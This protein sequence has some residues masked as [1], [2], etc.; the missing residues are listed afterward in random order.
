MS[1]IIPPTNTVTDVNGDPFVGA[2]MNIFE[3]GTTT[4]KDI[5]LNSDF[6]GAA[7]N[8][9]I[10]D[11]N[12]RFA[13]AYVNGTHKVFVTDSLGAEIP[14]TGADNVEAVTVAAATTTVGGTVV[15]ATTAQIAA[16][17]TG[18]YIDTGDT[19]SIPVSA[20]NISGTLAVGNIPNLPATK[21][22]S[23]TFD[24]ARLPTATETTI[25]AVEKATSAEATA[26]TADKFMDAALVQ[27]VF[28]ANSTAD[29]TNKWIKFT[30]V[31]GTFILQWDTK[32]VTPNAS[33]LVSLKQ[34][35]ADTAYAILVTAND[36]STSRSENNGAIVTSTTQITLFSGDSSV[37]SLFF[38]VLGKAA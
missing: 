33:T 20:S 6:T 18:F 11:S 5:F 35:M 23:L 38:M 26:G 32:T 15:K 8:P 2:K 25:G 4:K 10:S 31:A 12:G 36:A 22:T 28:S 27:A 37:S 30:T 17:T 13:T 24:A 19:S 3:P 1:L 9:I 21:I 7:A 29:F 16:Q 34:T 14:G